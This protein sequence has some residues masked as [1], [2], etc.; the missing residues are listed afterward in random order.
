ML[1]PAHFGRRHGGRDGRLVL[2]VLGRRVAAHRAVGRRR[3]ERDGHAGIQRTDAAP[4][5]VSF[6]RIVNVQQRIAQRRPLQSGFAAAGRVPNNHRA[7]VAASTVTRPPRHGRARLFQRRD[8]PVV[9]HVGHSAVS[10]VPAGSQE[11]RVG[12]TASVGRQQGRGRWLMRR[13]R[14]RRPADPRRRPLLVQLTFD[15]QILH[16]VHLQNGL[17][18][19]FAEFGAVVVVTGVKHDERA[20]VHPL[21]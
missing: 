11:R 19:I 9:V 20:S 17:A 4:A 10:V 15:P 13:R 6:H 8:R 21:R 1:Q 5:L 3:L 14:R 7:L 12:S 16:L 18:Q 2:Q